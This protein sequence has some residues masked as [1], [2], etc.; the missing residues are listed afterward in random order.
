MIEVKCDA[1][2]KAI[3]VLNYFKVQYTPE[4]WTY[5]AKICIDCQEKAPLDSYLVYGNPVIC[6]PESIIQ[7]INILFRGMPSKRKV[8][9]ELLELAKRGVK[10]PRGGLWTLFKYTN[11][12]NKYASHWYRHARYVLFL[13]PELA[14]E[15]GVEIGR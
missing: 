5:G 13:L 6:L 14:D 9:F 2:G 7:K 11:H 10:S 3:I 4:D 1:C 15:L 8:A 12:A